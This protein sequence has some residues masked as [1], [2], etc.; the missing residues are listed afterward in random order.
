MRGALHPLLTGLFLACAQA[1]PAAA[2]SYAGPM[3]FAVD[4]LTAAI[5]EAA[6][7]FALPATWIRAVVHAES[8]G[9]PH[10]TSPKGAM[11]LMQ[12]MPATW[13]KLRLIHGLGG[14]PY[15]PHDNIIAGAAYIR[16]LF[17]RYGTPGWIAAYNAGPGRYEAWLKGRPLPSETIAYVATVAPNLADDGMIPHA[18]LA[19]AQR[20]VWTQSALFITQQDHAGDVT[21]ASSVPPARTT[22]DAPRAPSSRTTFVIAPRSTGLF[23]ARSGKRSEP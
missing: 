19:I 7:R 22:A 6:Q 2:Q 20:I 4:P 10:A 13:S 9:N 17:D 5:A 1:E 15:D 23:V 3:S 8:N 11:G 21:D 14:N 18:Q 12:V 16:A